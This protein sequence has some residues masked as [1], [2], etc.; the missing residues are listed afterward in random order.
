VVRY[1][2]GGVPGALV[3]LFP[4]IGL[5]VDKFRRRLGSLSKWRT[6]FEKSAKS[7]G[8]D[9]LNPE[10]WYTHS[11][12]KMTSFIKSVSQMKEYYD[13]SFPV[14][15]S[16]LFPN[17]GID[18]KRFFRHTWTESENRRKF[19]ETIAKKQGFDPLVAENWY[20]PENRKFCFANKDLQSVLRF[21]SSSLAQALT[22][23]FPGIG[24]D[25]SQF[26]PK[27]STASNR[28][29]Y[30]ENFAAE[31]G[32]DPFSAQ[33]WYTHIHKLTSAPKAVSLTLRRIARHHEGSVHKAVA[34]LFPNIGLDVSQL[35]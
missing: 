35:M 29:K 14:A 20:L 33:D 5:N 6:I 23:L 13:G 4:D 9:P 27:W 10:N 7:H 34:D 3:A 15:V 18:R 24:F 25:K 12:S 26:G 32:F 19:F 22:D 16:S 17:I 2:S 31:N 30:L 21:H 8:F 11:W 28:R 1:Y